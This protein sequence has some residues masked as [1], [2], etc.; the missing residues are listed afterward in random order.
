MSGGTIGTP[1]SVNGVVTYSGF[2]SGCLTLVRYAHIIGYNEYAFFG[3][4]HPDNT[5]F[6]CREI[7]SK[8]QRD[9][10]A[11]Y[12]WEAQDEIENIIGYPLCPKWFLAEEHRYTTPVILD[13]AKIISIGTQASTILGAGLAV[14][15]ATDPAVVTVPTTLT[16]VADI[17]VY[18]PNT[19]IAIIPLS[20]S[21]SGGLLEIKIPKSRL[22]DIDK[23]DNP[24]EGWLDDPSLYQPTVD[25][26]HFY[27]DPTS[28]AN[29]IHFPS[30]CDD[31][32][33]KTTTPVCVYTENA[34]LG[35]V[36]LGKPDASYCSCSLPPK[37]VS[38]NYRAGLPTLTRSMEQAIVRLA[39]SRMPTE[40]CGCD[41]TQR[42][43]KRDRNVPVVLDRERL[44]CPFGLSD[45][46]WSAWKLAIS[47]TSFRMTE[48]GSVS[49]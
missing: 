31:E 38:I 46:A 36:R 15:Y 3:I 49:C 10:I 43:W 20:M 32:C 22:V 30:E 17:N 29:L 44:N 39:H 13:S 8:Y 7:W 11:E 19:D 9:E 41:V 16:S 12:L 21:I 23:L 40:P 28:Q 27:T 42:L 26:Y 37:R 24:V 5:R 6:A 35:I 1:I 34:D 25:V 47:M 4:S 45:G 48:F 18:Y 33:E 14:S 2:G